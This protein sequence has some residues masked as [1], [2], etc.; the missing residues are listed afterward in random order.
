MLSTSLLLCPVAKPSCSSRERTRAAKERHAAAHKGARLK[1]ERDLVQ[2]RRPG[3]LRG[4]STRRSA[5]LALGPPHRPLRPPP[6]RAEHLESRSRGCLPCP[7][8]R[9]ARGKGGGGGSELAPTLRAARSSCSCST[10]TTATT[11]SAAM[12]LRAPRCVARTHARASRLGRAHAVDL[13]L[14]S[15]LTSALLASSRLTQRL[16][17]HLDDRSVHHRDRARSM[18]PRRVRPLPLARARPDEPTS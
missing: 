1:S 11:S 16:R 17:L 15:S 12:Y 10:A 13:R 18:D 14:P 6:R 5:R 7:F 8:F 3:R 4:L 2:R 9:R